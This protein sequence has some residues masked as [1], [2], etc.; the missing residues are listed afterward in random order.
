MP[1]RQRPQRASESSDYLDD[2]FGLVTEADIEAFLADQDLE[3]E[4]ESKKQDGFW[5][6]QTASGIGMI[7]LGVLYSL[8]LIGLFPLGSTLLAD[9]VRTLPI[10]ASVL[11]MLTGFGVLS[12]SPA[13]R[14]RRKARERAAKIRAAQLRA[15][16]SKTMGR[17]ASR[18]SDVGRRAEEAVEKLR[19]AALSA[20]DKAGR[21]AERSRMSADRSGGRKRLVKSQR[22]RKISGVASGIANY[23]GIDPTIVRIAFVV[24]AIFGQG[25]G[26][27][28]YLILSA[29]LPK[30]ERPKPEP[31]LTVRIL[32][33]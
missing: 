5:N 17:G 4:V 25:M 18:G 26:V 23:F 28:L 8:Q 16:Q 10:L 21:A 24:A 32:K 31:D 19:E 3:E 29:V 27:V 33:D 13:A 6:L 11:I 1:T 22:D 15:A 20:R 9:L 14:R 12:W 30:E 2:D 7:G